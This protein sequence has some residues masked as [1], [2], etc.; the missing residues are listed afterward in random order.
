M[1]DTKNSITTLLVTDDPA[2]ESTA[3]DVAKDLGNVLRFVKNSREA[4]GAAFDSLA[5]ET[6][7]IVDVDSEFGSHCMINTIA[8]LV[9]VIAVTRKANPWVQSMRHHRRIVAEV[10]KPVSLESLKEAILRSRDFYGNET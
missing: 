3:R 6:L 5:R 10:S 8:G 1:R 2:L 7:V 9:P 4:T